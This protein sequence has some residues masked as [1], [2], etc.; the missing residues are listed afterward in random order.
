MED[1]RFADELDIIKEIQTRR[2]TD[3]ETKQAMKNTWTGNVTIG[4]W[5]IRS[6]LQ[7]KNRVR[8]KLDLMSNIDTIMDIVLW[9][10]SAREIHRNHVFRNFYFIMGLEFLQLIF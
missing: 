1:K 9:M 3:Y 4:T 8:G 7:K 6:C 5:K 2:P 10:D